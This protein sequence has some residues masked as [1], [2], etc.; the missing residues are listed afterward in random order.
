MKNFQLFF[1]FNY[2]IKNIKNGHLQIRNFWQ[3]FFN[4]AVYFS[5]NLNCTFSVQFTD[6]VMGTSKRILS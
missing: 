2:N 6:G 5:C 4:A 1:K 3:P